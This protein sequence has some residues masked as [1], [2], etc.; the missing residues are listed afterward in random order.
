MPN[1][2]HFFYD[3]E[4][5]ESQKLKTGSKRQAAYAAKEWQNEVCP[6]HMPIGTVSVAMTNLAIDA[7]M[8]EFD[9]RRYP[10][11][12]QIGKQLKRQVDG[13]QSKQPRF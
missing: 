7:G 11:K 9:R 10:G 8:S 2:N 4:R 3:P 12:T 1:K 6:E 13:N 5:C